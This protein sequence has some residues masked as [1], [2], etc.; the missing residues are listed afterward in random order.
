MAAKWV[1]EDVVEEVIV[2][3]SSFWLEIIGAA[4]SD[5]EKFVGTV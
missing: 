5:S 3:V 1:N 2:A 4:W